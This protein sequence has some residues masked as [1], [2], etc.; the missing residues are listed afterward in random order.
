MIN[1]TQKSE[2]TFIIEWDHEDPGESIFNSFTEEDFIEVLRYYA[3]RSLSIDKYSRQSREES[4][5]TNHL[6]SQDIYEAAFK[7]SYND[8]IYHQTNEAS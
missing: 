6:S 7:T 3:E 5:E 1:V 4:E 8:E 2:N